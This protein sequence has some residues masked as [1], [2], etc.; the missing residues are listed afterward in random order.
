MFLAMVL[1]N[2]KRKEACSLT[3][4][5]DRAQP[6]IDMQFLDGSTQPLVP[7]PPEVL[8]Q[9]IT[10]LEQGQ[11][12]FSSSVF[13]ATIEDVAVQRGPDSMRAHIAAWSIEHC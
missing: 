3:L 1:T 7:P 13:A 4:V 2:A 11:R 8:L 6:R 12:E 5:V 9:I 10:G